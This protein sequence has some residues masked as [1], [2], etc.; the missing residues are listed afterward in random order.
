MKKKT[1]E[2][3][4]IPIGKKNLNNLAYSFCRKHMS[5]LL[6]PIDRVL[7]YMVE[8]GKYIPGQAWLQPHGRCMA[9]KRAQAFWRVVHPAYYEVRQIDIDRI[10]F[11][12][13]TRYNREA[14]SPIS[15][16]RNPLSGT[17]EDSSVDENADGTK[18]NYYD[19]SFKDV[20][21]AA[22]VMREDDNGRMRLGDLDPE[23]F[24]KDVGK[25][26][27]EPTGKTTQAC[28]V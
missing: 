18:H 7:F 3:N 20:C 26:R 25:W 21:A 11:E 22:E 1:F 16:Q 15:K 13:T 9:P 14:M 10:F 27:E 19:M 17:F 6:P 2:D 8:S 28:C 5:P 4:K 12:V 24:A 23:A